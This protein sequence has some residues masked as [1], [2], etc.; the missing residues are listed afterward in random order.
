M[1]KISKISEHDIS[2]ISNLSYED[3]GKWSLRINSTIV[4]MSR[5]FNS[6]KKMMDSIS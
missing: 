4:F 2:M 3:L 5:D 1:I 6:C